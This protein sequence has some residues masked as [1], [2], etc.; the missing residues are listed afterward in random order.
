MPC[1]RLT[2][3]RGRSYADIIMAIDDVN[4]G[5]VNIDQVNRST[6]ATARGSAGPTCQP[7]VASLT[8]RAH[9]VWRLGSRTRSARIT[10][11]GER[12]NSP[13]TQLGLADWDGGLRRPVFM[14]S[15]S[16]LL[17]L[18]LLHLADSSGPTYQ[19]WWDQLRLVRS[20]V[21]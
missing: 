19:R 8:S 3:A 15:S 7:H 1:V 21:A 6:G 12:L 11:Q 2:S 10:V 5:L 16:S 4:V 20:R 18:L 17:F 9:A 13:R 14:F